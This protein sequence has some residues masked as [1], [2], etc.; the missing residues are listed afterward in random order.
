MLN[1]VLLIGNLGSDPE[2]RY[3]PDGRVLTTFRM[4]VHT[5]LGYDQDGQAREEV[6]WFTVVVFGRQAERCAAS[7]QKGARIFVEGRLRSRSFMGADGL[8]RFQLQVVA[9]R[10]IFLSSPRQDSTDG[11]Q[12]PP[13]EELLFP[14]EDAAP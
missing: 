7:L 8:P 13:D 5:R 6:E 2:M 10:V 11:G 14:E 3:T 9:R 1:R 12:A 4:A